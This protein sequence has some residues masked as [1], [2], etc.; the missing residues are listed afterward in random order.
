[1]I[2]VNLQTAIE[3]ALDTKITQ[4]DM[5]LGCFDFDKKWNEKDL[6]KVKEQ[7]EIQIL[8]QQK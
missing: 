1:M 8:S 5:E 3:K 2:K 6:Q 7:V 4:E